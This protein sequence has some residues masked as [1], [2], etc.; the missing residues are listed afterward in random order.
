MVVIRAISLFW[1]GLITS[2]SIHSDMI[3]SILFAPVNTFFDR[4][5]IGR[6]LNRLSKD[7]SLIDTD[8]PILIGNVLVGALQFI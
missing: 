1:R 3:K 5:P 2:K 7:I 6:I 4:M 8:V